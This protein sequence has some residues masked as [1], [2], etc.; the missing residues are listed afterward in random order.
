MSFILKPNNR[1]NRSGSTLRAKLV[2]KV[3]AKNGI[4]EDKIASIT[5]DF[6][7]IV[8]EQKLSDKECV[9]RD[10]Q[11][12]ASIIEA[13]NIFEIE[14]GKSYMEVK[15]QINELTTAL[16]S[17]TNGSI[18][19]SP[20]WSNTNYNI[21]SK[22]GE[23]INRPKFGDT[24]DFNTIM[25]I[26]VHKGDEEEIYQ[27]NVRVPRHSAEEILSI[28]SNKF[29]TAVFSNAIKNQNND[30]NNIHGNLKKPSEAELIEQ[31]GITNFVNTNNLSKIKLNVTVPNTQV[32]YENF[33]TNTNQYTGEYSKVTLLNPE[34]Y[35]VTNLSARDMIYIKN[36]LDIELTDTNSGDSFTNNTT[37]NSVIG[38]Y[39]YDFIN[40]QKLKQEFN[41]KTDDPAYNSIICYSLKASAKLIAQWEI[42]QGDDP[43]AEDYSIK[44][45]ALE[46]DLTF[47]SNVIPAEDIWYN[48]ANSITFGCIS[49]GENLAEITNIN[50]V[51]TNNDTDTDKRARYVFQ[52]GSSGNIPNIVVCLKNNLGVYG[53]RIEDKKKIGVFNATPGVAPIQNISDSLINEIKLIFYSDYTTGSS[54]INLFTADN[55]SDAV[56]GVGGDSATNK[57]TDGTILA[58]LSQPGV[59]KYLYMP[60]SEL[61]NGQKIYG[62]LVI[63]LNDS[64]FGS[65]IAQNYHFVLQYEE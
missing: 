25:S 46:Q 12:L 2:K 52:K 61:N 56:N 49:T 16:S 20:Q 51:I 48:L 41:I 38:K 53:N 33:N 21:L 1:K 40:I 19:D 30:L 57:I 54:K 22:N 60:A 35:A 45:D 13:A 28:L 9:I 39:G 14:P 59:Y 17:A 37:V 24:Q 65:G 26:R 5:K 15:E 10:E 64:I 11:Q 42:I 4:G 29:T 47:I 32:W 34:T 58:N 7:I 36:N 3:E 27:V 23:V 62:S 43:S 31:M 63:T 8:R 18:I 44:T 55:A 6:P 50:T